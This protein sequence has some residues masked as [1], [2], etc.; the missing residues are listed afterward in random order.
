MNT[1]KKVISIV[2][3]FFFFL[4]FHLI[5]RNIN[6]FNKSIIKYRAKVGKVLVVEFHVKYLI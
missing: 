3:Q 1:A 2:G 6:S 4:N 5:I